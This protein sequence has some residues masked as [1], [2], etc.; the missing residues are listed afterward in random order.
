MATTNV[1]VDLAKLTPAALASLLASAQEE[2]QRR[3][4][5]DA[6]DAVISVRN[7]CRDRANSYNR[8]FPHQCQGV[9]HAVVL[10]FHPKFG[11]LTASA[12]G[13]DES[14]NRD[15]VLKAAHQQLLEQ[16]LEADIPKDREMTPI[17]SSAPSQQQT[18]PQGN[19]Q[20]G[21][22]QQIRPFQGNNNQ[23]NQQQ[24]P[25][26]GNNNQGNQQ[27]RPFQGNNNQGNQQQRPFQGNP[28]QNSGFR[29]ITGF[30]PPRQVGSG[31]ATVA[32]AS[33]TKVANPFQS[34]N[35]A[36]NAKPAASS[37]PLPDLSA[38]TFPALPVV[39]RRAATVARIPTVPL[40]PAAPV[41]EV[42]EAGEEASS[43]G[44]SSEGASSEEPLLGEQEEVEGAE[45]SS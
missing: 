29:P 7:W 10:V 12:S 14:H 34:N 9:W 11:F 16:L 22:Q 20:Q 39:T 23:G 32:A 25:F 5:V 40:P 4:Q 45:E 33:S 35:K 19:Q 41:D 37:T 6:S 30:K 28:Q 21:N 26:Q 36:A 15:V 1:P 18:R 42:V 44:A 17:S 24:R 13:N 31:Q 38:M 3:Q 27:Q 8:S 2:A 43:E